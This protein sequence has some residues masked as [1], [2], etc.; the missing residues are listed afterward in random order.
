MSQQ[1][2]T[3]PKRPETTRFERLTTPN[4]KNL[5]VLAVCIFV[6]PFI[7]VTASLIIYNLSG[8]KYLDRSRPGYMPEQ[9]EATSD[10]SNA[11]SFSDSGPIDH[12]T[13]DHYLGDLDR[14][15]R[16]LHPDEPFFS[17]APLTNDS[18]GLS[19]SNPFSGS[20]NT[21]N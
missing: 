21:D 16:D 12:E 7:T 9:A 4:S 19:F 6:I 20:Q 2:P 14:L 17:E 13:L 8:D 11:P 10:S 3:P 5:L 18:L 15:T 1:P